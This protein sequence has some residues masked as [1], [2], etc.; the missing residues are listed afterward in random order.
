MHSIHLNSS[1]PLGSFCGTVTSQGE[2]VPIVTFDVIRLG[3]MHPYSN[4]EH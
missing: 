4:N 3:V 2:V 1:H